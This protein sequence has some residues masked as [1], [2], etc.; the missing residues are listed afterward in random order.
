MAQHVISAQPDQTLD[1]IEERMAAHQVRRLPVVDAD[2]KPIGVLSVNDLA[3][4]SVQPD[5]RMT[6]GPRRCS[7]RSRRS[8]ALTRSGS[9][10]RRVDRG[11][12][13]LARRHDAHA[14]S[15]D[16]NPRRRSTPGIVTVWHGRV[17]S[18]T[19]NRHGAAWP[20][21]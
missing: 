12:D 21:T 7:R 15:S 13:H 6:N 11:D 2:S 14:A 20:R 3:I 5:T 19:Q 9:A 18:S 8:A 16:G 1:E 10:A 4:E 17:R